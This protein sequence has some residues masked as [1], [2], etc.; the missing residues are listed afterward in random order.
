MTITSLMVVI[1][2]TKEDQRT[3]THGLRSALITG[4][5]MNLYVCL[6]DACCDINS[7]QNVELRNPVIA[8][9]QERLGQ[10]VEQ[11][12]AQGV[13]ASS[14]VD[15][16]DDWPRAIVKAAQRNKSD[17]MFKASHDHGLA[18]RG[19]RETSDWIVLRNSP[20]P[21]LIVKEYRDWSHRRVLAAINTHSE[22]A[23]HV[24]LN[25]AIIEFSRRLADS[26]GSDVHFVTAF[27][28][29]FQE[30]NSE[31]LATQCGVPVGQ[32]HCAEGWPEDI[33]KETA[34]RLEVDLIVIGNVGRTGMVASAIG[35]TAEKLLDQTHSDV[36]VINQKE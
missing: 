9:Y 13:E 8:N 36:L 34:D 23:A 7:T 29:R 6:N 26:Y 15:W 31:E 24:A 4:A 32:I 16:A 20:C 28:G 18:E 17:M 2:P 33:I 1:D 30:P 22:D 3:F 19:M 11:A 10:L 25:E 27:K 35:N 5:K 21:V 14:E 12:K